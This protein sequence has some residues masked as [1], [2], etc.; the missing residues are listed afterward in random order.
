M[1]IAWRA[2]FVAG[3]AIRRV[4][5][6]GRTAATVALGG[7]PLVFATAR[8][9]RDVSV[10]LTI[11]AVVGGAAAAWLVDDAPGEVLTPVPVGATL[12]RALRAFYVTLVMVAMMAALVVVASRFTDAAVSLRPQIPLV[13]ATA[14]IS[15]ALAIVAYRNEEQSPGS[16]GMPGGVVTVVVTGGLAVRWPGALPTLAPGPSFAHWW[17]LGAAALVVVVAIGRDP[18]A[19]GC[20]RT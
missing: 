3:R 13:V 8:H 11:A 6:I 2:T 9:V 15:V 17:Y 4:T 16:W 18:G 10:T 19:R 12:R 14:C 5:P 7:A 20:D 1:L